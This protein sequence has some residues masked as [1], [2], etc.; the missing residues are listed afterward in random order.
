MHP[1]G[2]RMTDRAARIAGLTP[3]TILLDVGC[4]EGASLEFLARKFGVVPYGINENAENLL[5]DDAFFDAVICECVLSLIEDAAKAIREIQR[6]LK[7]GGIFIVSDVCD[8]EE[9]NM[10]ESMYTGFDTVH[11]EEHRAALVTYAA[12]M[13]GAGAELCD[14]KSATYYLLICRKG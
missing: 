7:P 13:H 10:T 6:V 4:G 8:K 12:E 2:L 9:L 1:G 3:G 14:A 5:Y 11:I